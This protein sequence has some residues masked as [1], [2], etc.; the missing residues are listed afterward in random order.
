VPNIKQSIK[1]YE[2]I[3]GVT[4]SAIVVSEALKVK[5][6]FIEFSNIKIELIQ[7]LDQTSPINN[8][9][10]KNPNGGLHHLGIEVND[11]NKNY[12]VAQELNLEPIDEPSKGYH[13]KL[14]FFLHPKKMMNTL[15]ELL[16]KN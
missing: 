8:F 9:L 14:L 1:H 7:P 16:S 13:G 12:K 5:I 3:F 2:N 6:S 11:I 4:S 15:I 10:N